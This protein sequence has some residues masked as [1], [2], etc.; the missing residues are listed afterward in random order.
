MKPYIQISALAIALLSASALLSITPTKAQDAKAQNDK[1]EDAKAQPA[2]RL[3]QATREAMLVVLADERNAEAQYQAVID[4]FG[5]VRPFTNILRAEQQHQRMLVELFEKYELPV[6]PN[7]TPAATAPDT[8][9]E[10]CEEAVRAEKANL[11]LYD[12]F[13]ETVKE[14]DIRRVFTALRDASQL[15]HLPA[16]ERCAARRGNAPR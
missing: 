13:L 8:L 9:R 14:P 16:F 12:K 4:K 2:P 11:G 10:A 6:P 5:K 1:T 15:R 3:D 7:E